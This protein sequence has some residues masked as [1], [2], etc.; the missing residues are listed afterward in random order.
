M[1]L[2]GCCCSKRKFSAG[3]FLRKITMPH[4]LYLVLSPV[5]S[6]L[7]RSVPWRQ[8]T[9]KQ[10][11]SSTPPAPQHQAARHG[12]SVLWPPPTST[13]LPLL[14]SLPLYDQRTRPRPSLTIDVDLGLVSRS[15]TGG[16]QLRAP[17]GNIFPRARGRS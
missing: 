1:P 12:A 5:L 13:N 3:G 16:L 15:A 10:I 2:G 6:W 7:P 8:P 9:P 11:P 4:G 17:V 14:L